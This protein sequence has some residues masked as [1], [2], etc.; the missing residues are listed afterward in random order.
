MAIANK[1]NSS[2]KKTYT[3]IISK[4]TKL[5]GEFNLDAR[6]FIEG[7]VEGRVIC[8]NVVVIAKD[9][10]LIG[11]IHADYVIING[12]LKGVVFANEIEVTKY[13]VLEA[14]VITK[15]LIVEK[16]GVFKGTSKIEVENAG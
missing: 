8:N 2:T 14:E 15:N 10:V 13:G 9:G 4:E 12:L 11:D 16:G 3:T 7:Y 6:F 5:K 1:S